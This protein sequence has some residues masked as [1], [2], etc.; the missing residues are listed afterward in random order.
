MKTYAHFDRSE[1][2]LIV[3]TF[4]GAKE[5]PENFAEYLQGLYQ[6]YDRKEAFS[7]V[8]DAS[9]APTPNPSYQQKQAQWMKDHESM[10]QEYCRGVAYVMPN[11]LLRNVLKLIFAIQKNPV[12]FE[13]FS[14]KNEG[15]SWA[16]SQLV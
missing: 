13:V 4:T 11:F 9:D 15:V 8:F 1:F 2:P 6:N 14:K 5:T 12:P 10:I 7:L 3:V 16:K